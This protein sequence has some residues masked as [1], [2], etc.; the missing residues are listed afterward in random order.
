MS[1]ELDKTFMAVCEIERSLKVLQECDE[2]LSLYFKEFLDIERKII[3]LMEVCVDGE[4]QERLH[5]S[6]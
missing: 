1:N 6:E 4:H 2:K 3:D 5:Q